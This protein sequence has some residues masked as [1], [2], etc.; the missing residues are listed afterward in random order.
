MSKA[1]ETMRRIGL[2]L[3]ESRGKE[4]VAEQ[5]QRSGSGSRHL[6]EREH[7]EYNVQGRDLL[8][9]LSEFF[10]CLPVK[11]HP[12]ADT[13]FYSPIKP[14][15]QPLTTTFSERDAMSDINFPSSGYAHKQNILFD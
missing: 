13:C 10:L 2:G 9:V 11:D 6:E 5:S 15:K 8:S 14:L 1:R 12:E 7:D 3:I 4:I